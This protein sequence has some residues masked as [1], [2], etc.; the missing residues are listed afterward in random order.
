LSNRKRSDD[1]HVFDD[2]GKRLELSVRQFVAGAEAAEV[3]TV[4]QAQQALQPPWGQF[5]R[6][7]H[8]ANIVVNSS[9]RDVK[10]VVG[11][12]EIFFGISIL[13]DV[14]QPGGEVAK[15]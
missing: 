4:P 15:S 6:F 11:L 12:Y 5:R 8:F 9:E 14:R 13:G 3:N 10:N 1:F 2:E 7:S